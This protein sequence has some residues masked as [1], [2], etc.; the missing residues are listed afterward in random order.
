MNYIFIGKNDAFF[1]NQLMASKLQNRH[2]FKTWH[3]VM[4][5]DVSKI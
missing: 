4:Y 3:L 2:V 5:Y 1:Y